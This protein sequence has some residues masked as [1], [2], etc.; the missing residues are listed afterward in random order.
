MRGGVRFAGTSPTLRVV[1]LRTILFCFSACAVPALMPLVARDLI[2]GGA[3][4]YGMLLGS[5][6]VGGVTAAFCNRSLRQRLSLERMAMLASCG[7]GIGAAICA[8]SSQLFMTIPALMIA[9]AGW[10]I[11]LTTFNVTIQLGSPRWIIAR[12]VALYQMFASGGVAAG[13]WIFGLIAEHQGVGGALILAGAAQLLCVIAGF[14]LTFPS[15]A[16]LDSIEP[17]T[18]VREANA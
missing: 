1:L 4:I 7:T 8:M 18:A 12:S 9:G 3:E 10:L 5:F 15:L 16:D 11:A 6:G 13:S 17:P 2:K 14:W